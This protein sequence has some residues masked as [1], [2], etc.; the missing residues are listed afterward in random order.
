MRAREP[1]GTPGVS[2]VSH[3]RTQ[4]RKTRHGPCA[5]AAI[6]VLRAAAHARS[7]NG[8]GAEW[9]SFVHLSAIAQ[10]VAGS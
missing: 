2:I 3:I 7:A 8:E 9:N 10:G 4:Q 6:I 1:I 5:R